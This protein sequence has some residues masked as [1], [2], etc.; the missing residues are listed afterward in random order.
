[1]CPLRL[2]SVSFV[3]PSHSESG[4]GHIEVLI[5]EAFAKVMQRLDTFVYFRTEAHP[6]RILPL[7]TQEPFYKSVPPLL[8]EAGLMKRPWRRQHHR[9]SW[10]LEE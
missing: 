3:M 1:M 6:P 7:G 8:L 4:F 2:T 9:K 10:Q 5:S